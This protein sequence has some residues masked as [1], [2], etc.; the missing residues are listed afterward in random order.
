[1][2]APLLYDLFQHS[3]MCECH[4][5]IYRT[6]L[7]SQ[8]TS[9]TINLIYFLFQIRKWRVIDGTSVL[10][11]QIIFAPLFVFYWGCSHSKGV[12]CML[13]KP[14]IYIV[15]VAVTWMYLKSYRA[16]LQF[17]SFPLFATWNGTNCQQ[18]EN[19]KQLLINPWFK[20][21]NKKHP[22]LFVW[23]II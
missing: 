4:Q 12:H 2:A 9:S 3:M 16:V 5:M 14:D 17:S 13:N 8:K 7:R 10:A 22:L 1:M 6:I 18:M 20:R 21:G 23:H 19:I 15:I 11:T